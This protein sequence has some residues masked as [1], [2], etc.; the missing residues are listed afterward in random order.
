MTV[1]KV[2][3]DK[4]DQTSQD[5]ERHIRNIHTLAERLPWLVVIVVVIVMILTLIEAFLG[6]G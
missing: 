4:Q 1:N 6:K 5:K 2:P 3:P